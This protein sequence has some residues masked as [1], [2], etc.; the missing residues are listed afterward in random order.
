MI[1]REY[2]RTRT[3]GV[4]LYRTYSDANKYLIQTDTGDIYEDAIDVEDTSHTYEE[5]DDIPTEN[6]STEEYAQV[7]RILMGVQDE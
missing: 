6:I 3:D 4:K 5:G 7:G 2:F 1:I